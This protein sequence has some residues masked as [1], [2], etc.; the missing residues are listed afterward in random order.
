MVDNAGTIALE[1]QSGDG[2]ALQLNADGATLS[3]GGIVSM[4]DSTGNSSQGINDNGGGAG[5]DVLTNVDNIIEGVGTIGGNGLGL[6]NEGTIDA[7][8]SGGTLIINT[9]GDSVT[10]NGT[11]EAIHGGT[12]IVD[13]NVT[14]SGSVAIGGG[15]TIDF[16]GTM[17]ENVTF[18][19]A[20]TLEL[21]APSSFAA[22][23][24]GISGSSDVLDL[25]GFAAATT[26]ATTGDGSYDGA[27][28]TTTLTV[29][30]SSDGLTDQFK[31]VGNYASS[32]WTVQTD[33]HGGVDIADPPASPSLSNSAD[34]N[35]IVASPS[36]PFLTGLA[37]NDVF[38]FKPGFGNSTIANFNPASDSIDIDHTLF[39]TVATILASARAID[40]GTDTLIVDAAHDTIT[41]K[42][43]TVA[44]LQAH[45]GDFHI[46]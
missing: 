12:L 33:G 6:V 20:G 31:L 14:G 40:G 42:N 39:A 9:S 10:N 1:S 11:L 44:Q 19:G 4:T 26:T 16:V 13:S 34:A 41:L 32:S 15:G 28:N 24:A 2:T 46:V 37:A 17:S 25:H 21:G 29:T 7:N 43:V 38:V 27:T 23:I 8:I 3:G 18:S 36:N 45:A 35:V 30:D 5:T 22:I